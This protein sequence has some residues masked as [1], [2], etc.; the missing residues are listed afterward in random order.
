MCSSDLGHGDIKFTSPL[1]GITAAVV[2]VVINLAVFFAWHVLWPQGTQGNPFAGTFEWFSA[3]IGIAAA[4]A[5][6]RYKIGIMPV[7]GACAL[8]GLAYSLFM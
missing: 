5:L 7:I 4:I 6:F 2:G 1:T 3:L 8:L